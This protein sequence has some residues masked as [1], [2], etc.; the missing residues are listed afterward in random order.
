[1]IRHATGPAALVII[2]LLLPGACKK[3]TPAGSGTSASAAPEPAPASSEKQ[4]PPK[5]ELLGNAERGKE[6]VKTFECNRCH[7]GTGLEAADFHKDC[8]QCH[9]DIISGKF[10]VADTAKVAKWKKNVMMVQHV[11]SLEGAGKRLRKQ[12]LTAFLEQPQDLRPNL[13]PSM[14]R[15]ALSSQQAADVAAYLTAGE[16]ASKEQ[17]WK[18]NAEAGR[19]LLET[20]A[21]GTCHLFTGADLPAKPALKQG[22]SNAAIELAPDLRFT[23]ERLSPDT[24]VAWLEEPEKMKPGTLMPNLGLT[25]AQ[26]RD[27]AEY[28]LHAPLKPAAVHPVPKRLAKLDRKV[29]FA[30]VQEKVLNRTCAHCHGNPD[31]AKGDGGPGNTG[32]FGY[33]PRHLDLSKYS[34]I[35]SGYVADDGERHSVFSPKDGAPRIVAALWARHDEQAGKPRPDLRGMPLGMPALPAEDIQVLE[36]WI[37]QGRPR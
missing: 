15:L 26:A 20:R 17:S 31:I 33:K 14:P 2:G 37:A 23:R 13:V 10:K 12:W 36:S 7:A 9:R 11:P 22:E 1:M 34:G 27:V 5:P 4:P 8:F 3:E 6:L 32:G 18:A 16:P 19:T 21:C 30:E 28:I 24:L 29:S 25:K 35:A